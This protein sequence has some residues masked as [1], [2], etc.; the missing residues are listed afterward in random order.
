DAEDVARG[1]AGAEPGE[2]RGAPVRRPVGTAV[3]ARA[4]QHA[5][6]MAPVAAHDEEV[7][8]PRLLPPAVP[9]ESDPAPVGRPG[10]ATVGDLVARQAVQA[11]P[12]GANREDLVVAVAVASE[13]DQAVRARECGFGRALARGKESHE[14]RED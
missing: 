1:R 11:S 14:G 12:V 8:A 6:D 13:D 10:R 4:P 7:L 5:P 9:R 2:D 3:E